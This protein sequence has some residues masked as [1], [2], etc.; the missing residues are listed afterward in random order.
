MQVGLGRPSAFLCRA[1]PPQKVM[2]LRNISPY[3]FI[4]RE[5]SQKIRKYM[6]VP[7]ICRRPN[8]TKPEKLEIASRA[9]LCANLDHTLQKTQSEEEGRVNPL[10]QNLR[11][12]NSSM[13]SN[14]VEAD[15]ILQDV[16]ALMEGPMMGLQVTVSSILVACFQI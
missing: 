1:V 5:F 7:K 13:R 6:L 9:L 10:L 14:Y 12:L 2:R 11:A 15:A 8:R 3:R 16:V 4:I